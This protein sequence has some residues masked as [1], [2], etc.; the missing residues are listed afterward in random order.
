MF[1][2]NTTIT[3]ALLLAGLGA[4]AYA[5]Q[6]GFGFGT[7]PSAEEI[8]GWDIDVRGSDGAGLP[9]GEGDVKRGRDVFMEQCA[10]CHGARGEGEPMEPLQGGVNSLDGDDP[11]KTIGSYWPYAPIL[12]DY[13][14]RAMPMHAPQS[15]SNDDVY[16]VTAFML[17]LNELVPEDAVMNA[18][19]LPQVE[20]PNRDGFVDDP[21]P[22]VANVPCI[23]NCP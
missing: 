20:M 1:G 6:E 14:R 21:R 10:A 9:E 23:G 16:A 18:E 3:A 2:R 22:D 7:E 19:T 8:A 11:Q 17:F 13:T 12:F 4:T 15:L 5:Q